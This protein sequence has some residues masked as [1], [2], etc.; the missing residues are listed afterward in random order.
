MPKCR[1]AACHS[2]GEWFDAIR[3]VLLHAHAS[4]GTAISPRNSYHSNPRTSFVRF[5]HFLDPIRLLTCSSTWANSPNA[6]L[7]FS[8]RRD[9]ERLVENFIRHLRT[10]T[11]S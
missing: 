10:R 6:L 7:S 9:R 2:V 4:L 11:S 8:G 3:G 1:E 5:T